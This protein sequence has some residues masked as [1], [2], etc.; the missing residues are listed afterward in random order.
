MTTNSAERL[1]IIG[2]GLVGSLLAVLLA[3]RGHR[4]E[5]FERR[6]DPRRLGYE[7]GRSINLA[8]AARGLRALDDAGL[9]E[10]VMAQTVL[11]R[12]RMVHERDGSSG[13]QR[14]GRDDSEVIWSVHR[15]RLNVALLDAAEAAGATLHFDRRLVDVDWQTLELELADETGNS[16]R[17]RAG[18]ILGTDGAG[19]AVRAAMQ[20]QTDLGERFEP[21]QHAYK[22]VMISP[23][24]G[25]GFKLEPHALHIWPRD[26][27]MVI[28]LAN[29]DGSFTGTLFLSED[30]D[31]GFASLD[32]PAA[33]QAFFAEHFPQVAALVDDL[34]GDFFRHPTGML[35]TLWLDRWHLDQRAL[36]LGDAAHAL[37]PFHGQGMNCGFEDA[38]ELAQC[39]D[40]DGLADP[41]A[42]FAGFAARRKANADAIA[43]M[44]LTNYI[45]MRDRVDD[46]DYKL[47][48]EIEAELQ[49]RHPERFMPRYA[50]V[51]FS[52]LPYAQAES[53]DRLQT[54]IVDE[55]ARGLTSA[56]DT[57]WHQAARLVESQLP[58]LPESAHWRAVP[59]TLPAP[60]SV[61]GPVA[62]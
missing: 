28:A 42:L 52:A 58:V 59:P 56:A 22:E 11:M 36:L 4:V 14:Y 2:A 5:V 60:D 23:A 41:Q 25:N 8:M 55:L 48:R 47:K 6:G 16:Y 37:V 13:L 44:A 31:P 19:S 46:P 33:V 35:G 27:F 53:H 50:L 3:Q 24:P 62:D 20:R 30:G 26:A 15:G 10:V 49:R 17:H 12:G 38:L 39:I 32:T 40:R 51:T 61:A 18:L 21:L 54:G 1:T 7:G 45:E 34:V 9:R 29:I 43:R 57:D